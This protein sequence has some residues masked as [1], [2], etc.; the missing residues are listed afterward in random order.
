MRG[1]ITGADRPLGPRLPRLGNASD[2]RKGLTQVVRET[3]IYQGISEPV[4]NVTGFW[5]DL[6][7][8]CQV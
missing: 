4:R 1:Q 5:A 7:R 3:R 6:F 2:R 8:M